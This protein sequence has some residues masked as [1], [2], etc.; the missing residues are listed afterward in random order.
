[1]AVRHKLIAVASAAILALTS[2]AFVGSAQAQFGWFGIKQQ[3][4]VVMTAAEAHRK[5]EAGELVLIDVRSSDEWKATG[6][7]ASGFAITM[8]QDTEA[9]LNAL[10]AAV[11]ADRGKPVA[12][13]CATGVRTTYLQ[14]PLKKMGFSDLVNVAE[15]MLGGRHG[16]GWIKAGLPV[17]R[18][19]GAADTSPTASSGNAPQAS[20]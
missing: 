3:L 14:K 4:G 7:P 18:W 10:D 17:R 13:I 12:V 11:G 8:H 1:M 15:G 9:F 20:R 2:I 5:A 16:D 6:V 19:T